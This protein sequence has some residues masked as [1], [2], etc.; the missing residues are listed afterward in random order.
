MSEVGAE[1]QHPV[2]PLLH[3][4]A[5][6]A[7]ALHRD[8]AQRVVLGQ[9]DH[10]LDEDVVHRVGGDHLP[11]GRARLHLGRGGGVIRRSSGSRVGAQTD[12]S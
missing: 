11:R 9:L 1:L 7:P 10:Q 5:D 2:P 12:R 3:G 6:A 8:G 4:H